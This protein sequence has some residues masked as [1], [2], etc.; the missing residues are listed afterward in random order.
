MRIRPLI[1]AGML[2]CMASHAQQLLP[3]RSPARTMDARGITYGV[4]KIANT[5]LFTGVADL[6][7]RTDVGTFRFVNAYRGT[8]FRTSTTAL[9]DDQYSNLLWSVPVT[10]TISAVVRQSW[11]L[12]QDSR[13][14]GLSSLERLNGAMGARWQPDRHIDVELLAG[15]ERTSQLGRPVTGSLF[16]VEASMRDVDIDE[17]L[18][19]SR[20][21]GDYH[22]MDAARTNADLIA[23]VGAIRTLDEGSELR[24]S[25]GYTKVGREYYTTLAFGS[26]DL[27]VESRGEERMNV[28]A[29]LRYALTSTMQATVNAQLQTAAIDRRFG[30]SS[31]D[32]PITAV[33]R[34]LSELIV[35]LSAELA[36]TM[37]AAVMTVGGALYRRDEQNGIAEV[38]AIEA[39]ALAALRSQENQRDNAT[40][41]SRAWARLVWTPS[42]R[43]T[44]EAD[45]TSWLLQYDTPSDLNADDRDELST[46]GAVRVARRISRG[47]SLGATLA[48]Q[49]V[50][51]VFLRATRSALN[52]QNRVLRLAPYLQIQ[53]SALTM[54]PQLEILA[55]YTVYD[56]ESN[57]A[58]ARSFSF[59]QMSWRDSIH[60]RISNTMHAEAQMLLRYSERA[61]LFWQQFAEAPETAQREWLAKI[62]IFS[63]PSAQWLVGAG[64]R[65]YELVQQP[66][67]SIAAPGASSSL[68]FWAPEVSLRFASPGGSTLSLSG[69]YE[70]QQV[71]ITGRR[72]LPNLLLTA[73]VFI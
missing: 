22:R 30:T 64:V 2:V 51:L 61:T 14:L 15:V 4:D 29:A 34:R 27:V 33:N 1:A 26:S 10:S 31:A 42:E 69:W 50:H 44:V 68:Q 49:H 52:N 18:L 71:N 16:G 39:S 11:T 70:F 23:T 13:S 48:G 54:R 19:T 41:R 21:V 53:T 73:R 60:V 20:F 62:L 8:A 36:Y 28:D 9:R 45:I 66:V 5:F 24:L 63:A 47:I 6:D 57:G 12:S 46:I 17:W 37:P 38:F 67:G 56:F 3:L 58:T 7:V 35:D 72:D 55:N 40:R 59:R 65:R 43:D 32:V 25:A